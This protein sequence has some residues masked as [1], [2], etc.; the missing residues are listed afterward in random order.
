MAPQSSPIINVRKKVND[1]VHRIADAGNRALLRYSLRSQRTVM[2]IFGIALAGVCMY[3]VIHSLQ[4]PSKI[5]ATTPITLPVDTLGDTTGLKPDP[6]V[7]GVL[8]PRHPNAADTLWIAA[9]IHQKYF[10]GNRIR[11]L[12]VPLDSLR[13]FRETHHYRPIR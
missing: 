9:S 12:E 5:L 4:R 6:H 10:I 3:Q 8:I 1:F 7:I 13:S 11:W 2:L